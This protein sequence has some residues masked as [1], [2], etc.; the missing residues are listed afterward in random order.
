MDSEGWPE[1]VYDPPYPFEYY[2]DNG[3]DPP[4]SKIKH[5]QSNANYTRPLAIRRHTPGSTDPNLPQISSRSLSPTANPRLTVKR[6]LS[7]SNNPRSVTITN[8]SSTS[9]DPDERP[10]KPMRTNSV[11]T[12]T[13]SP[14]KTI[15]PKKLPPQT[16]K[17]IQPSPRYEFNS[18]PSSSSHTSISN[19][20]ERRPIR[21][22]LISKTPFGFLPQRNPPRRII[23]EEYD[24][25]YPVTYVKPIPKK[26]LSYKKVSG[27]TTRELENYQMSKARR[28]VR[29]RSP[30]VE[31][32]IYET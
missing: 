6:N 14:K 19:L 28:V 32:I 25:N 5:H 18:F 29:V 8:H 31:R 13:S 4:T 7:Q 24:D 16:P 11:Y 15:Q 12:Q 26:I 30:P 1:A 3:R 2:Y 9:T 27:M 21:I 20:P 10:I 23:V 22:D 17:P